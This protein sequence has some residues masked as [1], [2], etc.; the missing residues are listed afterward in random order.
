MFLR[1]P[2]ASLV[3]GMPVRWPGCSTFVTACEQAAPC[4]AT[5]HTCAWHEGWVCHGKCLNMGGS[6]CIP[7]TRICSQRAAQ[8][9]HLIAQPLDAGPLRSRVARDGF[10]WLRWAGRVSGAWQA[11]RRAAGVLNAEGPSGFLCASLAATHVRLGL[12]AWLLEWPLF[13]TFSQSRAGCAGTP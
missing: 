2:V 12:L 1:E 3:H 13:E 7:K 9:D 4:P 8:S 11:A 10:R 5:A 6:L